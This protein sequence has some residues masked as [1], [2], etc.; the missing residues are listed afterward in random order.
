MFDSNILANIDPAN[1][2]EIS[3]AAETA[4][5]EMAEEGR[6]LR[7]TLGITDGLLEEI[8]S[9]AYGYYKQ[10][11]YKESLTLFNV[12]VG[13]D[14]GSYKYLLG[15]AATYHQMKE[16]DKAI[17]CFFL[18]LKEEPNNPIPAFYIADCFIKI[19]ATERALYFLD[20]VIKTEGTEHESLKEKCKLIKKSLEGIQ[21]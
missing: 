21:Q 14:L 17:L 8:Y 4:L 9:I 10:G 3:R 15:L 16:Y 7:E 13:A 1:H 20:H 18:A 12:L 5:K 19:N 6:T 2:E 11:K